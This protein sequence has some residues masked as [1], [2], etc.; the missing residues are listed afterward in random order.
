MSDNKKYYYLKLKENFFDNEE[1]IMLQSMPNGYVFSDILIKL[2]LRSL[3]NDGKLLLNDSV[4][5]TAKTLATIT[6]H[7]EKDMKNALKLFKDLGLI[8][9]LENGA[10]Y[11]LK[12]Q[13]FIGES[14]TEADRKRVYR[15][16]IVMEK[17]EEAVAL[18]EKSADIC[19]ANVPEM[20]HEKTDKNFNSCPRA[21]PPLSP[22]SE[23]KSPPEIEI[24]IKKKIEK[25]LEREQDLEQERDLERETEKKKNL[26]R[27][28]QQHL[29]LERESEREDSPLCADVAEKET[30]KEAVALQ[31][32]NGDYFS[33][34]E[35]L[36][37]ELSSTYPEVD[38]HT[39]LLKMKAWCQANPENR[40]TS[41]KIMRF[42]TG[43]LSRAT[44]RVSVKGA[45]ETR[46]RVRRGDF[47]GDYEEF[48]LWKYDI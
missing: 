27:E 34:T 10:I 31:L 39:E 22:K 29:H 48:G 41:E 15:E 47:S 8:E 38:V 7:K 3:K 17:A 37:E 33:V 19:P 9:V 46:A 6:R 14:S 32:K 40:K 44:E 16:K 4:F 13:S 5:Y 12:L 21:V 2:Y 18:N 28:I 36:V 43:W 25:D 42:I 26:E 35:N 1:L 11:M 24:E 23:D 45:D 30:M 20:S